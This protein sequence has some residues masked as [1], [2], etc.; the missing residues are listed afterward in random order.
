MIKLKVSF[1]SSEPNCKSNTVLTAKI[2]QYILK[3]DHE[4]TNNITNADYI[5]LNSCGFNQIHEDYS[6]ELIIGIVK[7]KK[8]KC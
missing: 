3:N 4:I 7:K 5:F 2:Y 1:I 6:K 8:K